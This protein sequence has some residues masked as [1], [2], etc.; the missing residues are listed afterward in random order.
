[1]YS[2]EDTKNWVYEGC[3]SGGIGCLDCKKPIVE[4][5]QEEL[6][7]IRQRAQ[8]HERNPD[9]VRSIIAEGNDDARE[10]ARATLKEVRS[11]MGLSYR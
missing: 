6:E 5:I 2:D 8:E 10:K 9:L 4:A 3:T 1:M 7:P 11:A